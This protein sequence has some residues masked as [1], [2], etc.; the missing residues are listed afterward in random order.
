MV[1]APE[2]G[3]PVLRTLSEWARKDALK[4]SVIFLGDNMYPEGM[5]ERKKHEAT[6]RLGPQL[7]VIKTTGAHGLFIPGN[8]DWANGKAEGLRVSSRARK[9][10]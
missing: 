7:A 5:T 6:E 4:T 3:E 8:H 2:P 10:Y 9:V 1:G